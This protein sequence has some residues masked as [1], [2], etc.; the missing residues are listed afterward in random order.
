MLSRKPRNRNSFHSI[1]QVE[2]REINI[3][4]DRLI[5]SVGRHLGI[6][7]WNLQLL[8]PCFIAYF[9]STNDFNRN[10]GID[11]HKCDWVFN[12]QTF[13]C[14]QNSILARFALFQKIQIF[15]NIF[16]QFQSRA[17]WTTFPFIWLSYKISSKKPP[18][19]KPKWTIIRC[20]KSSST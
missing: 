13:I 16:S 18:D 8:I 14:D 11:R 4:I 1:F 19:L 6:S 3:Y 12:R 15:S 20:I 5:S 17:L 7:I 2:C 10:K 9:D